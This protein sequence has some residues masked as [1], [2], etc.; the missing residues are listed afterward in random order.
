M[1][2]VAHSCDGNHWLDAPAM[3]DTEYEGGFLLPQ[4][5]GALASESRAA[6][7]THRSSKY[8]NDTSL[9]TPRATFL[10]ALKLR[11]PPL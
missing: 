2:D 8:Q 4:L 7:V 10:R 1:I 11:F 3:A 6:P 5:M 9:L